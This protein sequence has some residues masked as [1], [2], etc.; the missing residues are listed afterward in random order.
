MRPPPSS[1][2]ATSGSGGASVRIYTVGHSNH[3]W[4]VFLELLRRQRIGCLVDVRSIPESRRHPW[5]GRGALSS[6]LPG[7]GIQYQELGGV[8]GGRPRD[9]PLLAPG[10]GVDVAALQ[11]RPAFRAAM[12]RLSQLA[13]GEARVCLMCSEEDPA[14]CHRQSWLTPALQAAG[15]EVVHIRA[16]G[17]AVPAPLT[18]PLGV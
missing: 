14:R 16:S 13:R 4:T 7:A 17:A 2:A 18:L 1:S 6:A 8:L 9:P 10:G 15:L 3:P 12:G 11:A 5:F